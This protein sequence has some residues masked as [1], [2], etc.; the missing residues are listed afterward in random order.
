MDMPRHARHHGLENRSARLKHS[1]TPK[2]LFVKIGAGLALGYRRN[3]TAGSWVLRAADGKGGNRIKTIGLADDFDEA[4]DIDILDFWAAQDRA[5]KLGRGAAI[6]DYDPGKLL[7]VAQAVD[8][9]KLDLAA[10]GGDI[11][12]IARVGAGLPARL[13]DKVVGLVTARDLRT[14]RDG[15]IK[16]ELA[17]ATVNRVSSALKAALNLAANLDERISRRAWEKGL[18]TL[19][20]AVEARN[21]IL[22]DAV[23]QRVVEVAYAHDPQVGLFVDVIAVTGARPSQ[24]ARLNVDDVQDGRADTRLMVPSSRKGRGN[25]KVARRPVPIP[26]SLAARLRQA[27]GNRSNT[28]PL[29]LKPASELTHKTPQDRERLVRAAIDQGMNLTTAARQFQTLPKDGR[30]LG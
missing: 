15:L 6:G 9:Y 24:V 5:R 12:T 28:A 21:I 16:Q 1:V 3:T 30:S 19:P 2:P 25:K 7:T 11:S 17:P 22:P 13:A 10:R 18:M 29:L 27:V 26:A 23:V 8:A 14:W 4:D 20:D